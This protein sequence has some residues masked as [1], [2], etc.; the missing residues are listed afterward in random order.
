[1]TNQPEAAAGQSGA[2]SVTEDQL[3][4]IESVTDVK[5]RHLDVDDLLIELLE[6]VAALMEVDTVAVLLLDRSSQQ[7]IA[8][9]AWG[10]EEEVRQGVRL[11]VGHGFA[12]R[13]AAT[14]QPVTLDRVDSTTVTNPL[15]WER[16][17]RS[18]LGVPL[19]SGDNVLGV[20]HV[21]TFAGRRFT[22]SD[23]D[24]L[25]VVASRLST[26]IQARQL[27]V[28]RAAAR[29]L[30]RSLLPSRLPQLPDL[31]FAAR[32]VPAEVGGVGGDWY[33]AF[34]LPDGR[35]WVMVGDVVGHGM[36]AAVVMGRVRSTLRAYI[37]EDYPPEEVLARTDR[38]LRLFEPGQT[39][40]VLCATLVPP[41][42]EMRLCL[43]GHPPPALALQG[44]PATLLEAKP[45]M[46][47]G[48]DP[49]IPRSSVT[50]PFPPGA[51]FVA[52]TDGLVER[53]GKSLDEG[54]SLLCRTST[55]DEPERVCFKVMDALVGR[56]LP[57]DDIVLLAMRHS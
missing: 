16:G 21:G 1:M 5:L 34:A 39:A 49:D 38:K 12:G 31:Q 52:Y 37:L 57:Q 8:R 46:P 10:V 25:T 20:L 54:F 26:S 30:Q 47:L 7:L 40:T 48:I 50:V 35:I 44:S 13:I 15:L 29:V 42:N 9:A 56:E 51:L 43:A 55:P 19:M 27:E 28:E 17:I 18:M 41:F 33:D 14:K 2:E 23:S 45:G 11:S 22:E 53:R 32:Y 36:H 24:L 4:A 3:R 6:R